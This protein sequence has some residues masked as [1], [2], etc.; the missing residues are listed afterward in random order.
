MIEGYD[1]AH[2]ECIVT[3][4]Y[5][6]FR[7]EIGIKIPAPNIEMSTS[8]KDSAWY[9]NGTISLNPNHN[10]EKLDT[11]ELVSHEYL[12]YIQDMLFWKK[13]E[14]KPDNAEEISEFF[15]GVAFLFAGIWMS[16]TFGALKENDKEEFKKEIAQ[17]M[18]DKRHRT[19]SG[20]GNEEA[21][22]LF[23]KNDYDAKRFIVNSLKGR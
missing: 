23:K 3:D 16:M 22:E 9:G 2:L 13:V 10:P 7:D 14:S 6:F 15:E 8:V 4:L 20:V 18:E 21:I 1:I 5:Q 12:H 11:N 17:Y 19:K